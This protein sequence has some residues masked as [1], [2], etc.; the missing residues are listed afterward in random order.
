MFGVR[1]FSNPLCV[2]TVVTWRVE[3]HQTMKRRRNWRVVRHEE[4]K[5]CAFKL[6]DGSVVMH[7]TLY[8]QL[9]QQAKGG[10]HA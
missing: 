3:R 9:T 4:N 10:E 1:V 7:P 2:Q 8:A 5:P 6:A